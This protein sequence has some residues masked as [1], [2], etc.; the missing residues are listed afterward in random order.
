MLRS[1]ASREEIIGLP[2]DTWRRVVA[3][4]ED[5]IPLY[6]HVNDRISFGKAQEARLYA[7][8]R[9]KLS[10]NDYVLDG[11][12]GPGTTSRLI[13]AGFKPAVLVG[14][15]ESVKQLKT[16]KQNLKNVNGN[17][18]NF[19]RG[20]F[21]FLPFR[22]RA[23]QSVITCYALRDSLDISKSV[24]EYFRVCDSS[25]AF[26]DVDIG[27]PDNLLKRMASLLYV[28]YAMPLIARMVI[29]H[30]I[31]GNPWRMIGPTYTS[32]PTNRVLLELVTLAF[33]DTEL[34]EFLNGGVIVITGR[35]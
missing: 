16:A 10:P 34:K 28:K 8:Q 26:A 9:L 17:A 2:K 11:G 5:A 6:D 24:N 31:K 18:I 14:L 15:D 32:L 29:R 25:G 1:L 7:I 35:A 13:L 3:A 20:S 30:R 21:E 12:I 23:F 4:I 19:V 27:K 22:D 33:R